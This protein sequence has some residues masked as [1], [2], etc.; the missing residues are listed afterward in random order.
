MKYDMGTLIRAA[1]AGVLGAAG[2]AATGGQGADLAALDLGQWLTL[3]GTGL[4]SAGALLTPAKKPTANDK[5]VASV[6][7]VVAKT[8]EA[9]EKLTQQAVD[10]IQRVKDAVGNLGAVLPVPPAV[11]AD[12]VWQRPMGQL[13]QQV[14]DAVITATQPGG[15]AK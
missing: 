6:Q 12:A 8:S 5:A 4:M 11:V 14:L 2:A 13:G 1:V 9:H 15:E 3:V 7:D 10:S